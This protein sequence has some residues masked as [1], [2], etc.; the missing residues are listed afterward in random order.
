MFAHA[1][2]AIACGSVLVG[3]NGFFQELDSVEDAGGSDSGDTG[4]TDT[5]GTDDGG[6][7][8]WQD[9]QCMT[10]DLLASCSGATGEV[11]E[12]NCA[13][14]CGGLVNFTCLDAGGGVHGCFCVEPGPTNVYGCSQLEACLAS[15]GAAAFDACGTECFSR[16]TASTVRLYGALVHCA[17]KDCRETCLDS[18]GSCASCV[19][20]TK[21][22]LYGGCQVERTVCD[23][24]PD[25]E[26]NWP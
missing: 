25:D 17:E 10:Q 13:L 1:F 8:D 7:C 26:P 4:E 20:A 11:T 16:A 6:P 21:S 18:P 12:Y 2:L 14:E 5:G 3:C 24:D 22:G 15:C 23:Q 9:D 19:Q